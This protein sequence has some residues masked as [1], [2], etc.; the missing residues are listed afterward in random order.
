M[1]QDYEPT[2]RL[3]KALASGAALVATPKALAAATF[4][5]IDG[6]RMLTGTTERI[7]KAYRRGGALG[8]SPAVQMLARFVGARLLGFSP[9]SV[10]RHFLS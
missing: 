8:D 3:G 7:D 2:T 5:A 6:T 1:K 4:E 9:G 10:L